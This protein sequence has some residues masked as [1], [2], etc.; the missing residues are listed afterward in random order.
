MDTC[1]RFEFNL[2][3]YSYIEMECNVIENSIP[4]KK[5]EKY[6]NDEDRREGFR[7]AQL[8]YAKKPW[9]CNTCNVTILTGNKTKHLRSKK[10]LVS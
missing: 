1:E 3:K 8:R 6:S 7:L 4:H 10:H 5:G 9:T 2:N